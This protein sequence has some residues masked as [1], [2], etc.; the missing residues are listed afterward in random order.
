[1]NKKIL[2]GTGLALTL[3]LAASVYQKAF[4]ITASGDI[5]AVILDA[6]SL[7]P[8]DD[9]QF[10]TIVTGAAP[11]EVTI[12]PVTGTRT[13]DS[14]DAVLSGGTVGD[15]TFDL[16]GTATYPVTIDV[17]A[18]DTVTSGA[19]SMNVID[20][21]WSYNGGAVTVGDGT[22]TLAAAG[23]HVLSIGATLQLVG[24]QPA[25]TYT[26]SYDVTVN[27]Q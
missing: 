10:G 3:V 5:E 4:A 18:S 19:N 26:G 15:G 24:S 6:I 21:A 11:S 23:P 22:A 27:Y 20:F 13:L 2:L 25:G 1:M 17:P 16:N 12:A 8:G 9:L 14:G 7:T